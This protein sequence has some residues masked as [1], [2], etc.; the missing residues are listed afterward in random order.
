[1]RR[2]NLVSQEA[3]VAPSWPGDHP[4]IAVS[5][6]DSGRAREAPGIGKHGTTV[7]HVNSRKRNAADRGSDGGKSQR[8]TERIKL[9]GLNQY[10]TIIGLVK[11]QPFQYLGV[12]NSTTT[13]NLTMRMST[14]GLDLNHLQHLGL[15]PASSCDS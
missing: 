14:F 5:I 1:M 11:T 15:R 4:R 12:I 7:T 10:T 3:M 8:T 6:D 9:T 2:R 13:L